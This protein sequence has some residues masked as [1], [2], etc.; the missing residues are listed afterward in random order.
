MFFS[1]LARREERKNIKK[2]LFFGFLTVGLLLML[3][4]LG[5][6]ILIKIAV[7]LAD[8]RRT[9]A[10]IEQTDT[11]PPTLP[12]FNSLPEYTKE[13]SLGLSGFAEPGSTVEIFLNEAATGTVVTTA[14]GTFNF[15]SLNLHQD[16][17][18]IYAMATDEAGNKSQPSSRIMVIFDNTAPKLEITEPADGATFK[19]EKKRRI[20]I[21]GQTEENISLAINERRVILG[22]EGNFSS[23]F[24]LAD[25]ENKIKIVA[26]DLAG[27]QTEKEIKITFSP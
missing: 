10:P 12:R 2:A 16:K 26:A 6:P 3:I 15:S 22:S 13:S 4:F 25:G 27:N 5:I 18:E 11:F 1:R 24:L 21:L 20:T 19:G 23:E 8:I 9:T 17:N 14:E 7:F